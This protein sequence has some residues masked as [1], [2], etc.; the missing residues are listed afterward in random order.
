MSCW[1][2]RSE[3]CASDCPVTI[4]RALE[5]PVNCFIPLTE[6]PPTDHR[7]ATGYRHTL[8]DIGCDSLHILYPDGSSSALEGL[9]IEYGQ[10]VIEALEAAIAQYPVGC[11]LVFR[12]PVT[13]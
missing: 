10:T 6:P 3:P 12:P 7:L 8:S 1:L 13:R 2:C 11:R 4:L 9:A 5:P